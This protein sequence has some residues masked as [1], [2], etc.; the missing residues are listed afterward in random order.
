M[1]VHRPLTL[2]EMVEKERGGEREREREREGG[3][4]EREGGERDGGG[5][6]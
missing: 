3:E 5:G 6:R 2:S 1:C 4:R